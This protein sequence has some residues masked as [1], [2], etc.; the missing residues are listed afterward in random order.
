MPSIEE[1]QGVVKPDIVTHN[2]TPVSTVEVDVILMGTCPASTAKMMLSVDNGEQYAE[3]SSS[4]TRTAGSFIGEC[5]N[6]NF[7]IRYAVPNPLQNRDI[8]FLA[9][10]V[11]AEGRMGGI[12]TYT[13]SYSR[14]PIQL[15]GFAFVS[16]GD[17]VNSNTGNF[18]LVTGGQSVSP[19][20][21]AGP[22]IGLEVPGSPTGMVHYGFLGI[23]LNK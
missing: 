15:P 1:D 14:P 7:M 21:G 22:H 10:A 13:I 12:D 20:M 16:V 4:A 23:V 6:G 18:A 5:E 2:I 17:L 9:R 8:T 3:V 11:N 19:F